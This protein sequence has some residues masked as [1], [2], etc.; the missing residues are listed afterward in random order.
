MKDHIQSIQIIVACQNLSQ[1]LE[2]F[3]KQIGFRLE[4]IFPADFPKTAVIS[5][6]GVVLRLEESSQTVPVTLRLIGD[7]PNYNKI[8]EFE[9]IRLIFENSNTPL[10]IP[11]G[12]DEFVIS[13]LENENSWHQGRAGMEY[14]D[15][16]PSRLGGRFIASHIRIQAGGEVP[17]YVHFHQ[18]R[19]QMIFCL[20]GWS[21]LVYE[22]QG[23]PFMMKSGDCVLQPPEI[24][25]RVLECSDKFEVL[26]IGC[27]AVHQTLADYRMELPNDKFNPDRIFSEQRFVHYVAEQG[28]WT[29][30]EIEN[31]E[32]CDTGMSEATK[33]LADVKTVRMTAE[34]TFEVKHSGEFLFYFV[35]FGAL[36]LTS[37]EDE[38]Y[39]LEKGSSFN[40]PKGA[41]Y[42]IEAKKGLEMVRVS[43]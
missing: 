34:T 39:Q 27:P 31:V 26:E 12:T 5:G 16:I 4:L 23:E 33:G 13:R 17:D 10:E 40:L 29:I 1:T 35:R 3:T 11:E 8:T 19:F 22:D 9:N 14:R 42:L 18:I 20:S 25:H 28:L 32:L 36:R 15:L 6:F 21:R 30:S 43:L 24:R 7:F 41:E 2:F 38:V 37:P